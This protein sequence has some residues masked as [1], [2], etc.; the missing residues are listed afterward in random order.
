MADLAA[1]HAETCDAW[2]RD[3]RLAGSLPYS[4]LRTGNAMDLDWMNFTVNERQGHGYTYIGENIWWTTE[5]VMREDITG[6]IRDL[7]NEKPFYTFSSGAC[8]PGQMCGHYT[9]VRK[10]LLVLMKYF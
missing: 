4:D 7:Y 1:G 10:I 9:Q 6:I 2:H 8:V 5:S 3:G